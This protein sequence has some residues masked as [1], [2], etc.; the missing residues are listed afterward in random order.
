MFPCRPWHEMLRG[1]QEPYWP[2]R[3]LHMTFA[4]CARVVYFCWKSGKSVLPMFVP[5]L[6]YNYS[7][8]YSSGH[9]SANTV[10]LLLKIKWKFNSQNKRRT[11]CNALLLA[12]FVAGSWIWGRWNSVVGETMKRITQWFTLILSMLALWVKSYKEES[13]FK[14]C[15]FVFCQY[16]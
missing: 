2:D 7:S 8:K 13:I 15:I 16:I 12:L 11:I 5:D 1:R 4:Q 3:I 14:E 10:R 6:W 9:L